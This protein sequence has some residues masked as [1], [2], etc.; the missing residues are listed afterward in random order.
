MSSAPDTEFSPGA[1][2]GRRTFQ[3][4]SSNLKTLPKGRRQDRRLERAIEAR[5]RIADPADEARQGG[6]AW[7]NGEEVGGANPRFAH[8]AVSF[9]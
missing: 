5:R 7:I 2:L 8:L 1:G 9:D 4:V 6:R 3:A